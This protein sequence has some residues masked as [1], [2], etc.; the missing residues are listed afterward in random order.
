[1]QGRFRTFV[2]PPIRIHACIRTFSGR[3]RSLLNARNYATEHRQ[4]GPAITATNRASSV[5]I[6]MYL[7]NRHSTSR[8]RS[9]SQK[10]LEKGGG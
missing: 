6:K 9:H 3:T 1:M 4:D 8:R 5:S 7:N 2:A 10:V